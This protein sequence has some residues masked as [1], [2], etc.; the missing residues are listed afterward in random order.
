MFSTGEQK[1]KEKTVL[2]SL[3]LQDSVLIADKSHSQSFLKKY[4]EV[5]TPHTQQAVNSD[6]LCAIKY[7]FNKKAYCIMLCIKED[8]N[9]FFGLA[10]N[11]VEFFLKTRFPL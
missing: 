9:F 2:E 6:D 4:K 5:Q 11:F 10:L 1:K 7:S 8:T 3:S